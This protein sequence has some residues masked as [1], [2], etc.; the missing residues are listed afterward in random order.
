[1]NA[2]LD[3]LK[4]AAKTTTILPG[5]WQSMQPRGNC[6]IAS[7]VPLGSF[8]ASYPS[9]KHTRD[10]HRAEKRARSLVF[11]DR[12]SGGRVENPWGA[13]GNGE[14]LAARYLVGRSSQHPKGGE[15]CHHRAAPLSTSLSLCG[16]SRH[17]LQGRRSSFFLTAYKT[18]LSLPF[19]F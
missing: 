10:V 17:P 3:S 6:A 18:P 5:S 2:L 1:M 4:I 13:G 12:V 8:S 15:S 19:G 9:C 14:A 16:S 11:Y 7:A